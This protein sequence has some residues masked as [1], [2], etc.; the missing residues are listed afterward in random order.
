MGLDFLPLWVFFLT[1]IA[2]VLVTVEGGFRIGRFRSSTG[3]AEKEG[4]VSG[5]V[6]ATL[7]LLAFLLTFTFGLAASRFESRRLAVLEES[8]AIGT[9][10]L[11]AGLLP[12]PHR[13]EIQQLLRSYVEIRTSITTPDQI[14]GVIAKSEALHAQLWFQ[15]VQVAALDN[16]SLMSGLFIEAL[17]E[18][19]DLHTVR[20]YALRNRIPGVVWT[21]VCFVTVLAMGSTGYQVGLSGSRRSPAILPLVFAFSGVMTLI[22]DLDRPHEGMIRVSQ[23]TMLDLKH[24][25][26]MPTP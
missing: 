20:S 1:M 15:A 14:A 10:Y 5:I 13:N 16:H 11:R 24:G 2:I 22:A 3:A 7:A 21:V 9:T 19:I 23:Q 12:E 17:N 8:N 4:G 6:G 26:Q 18:T 25:M